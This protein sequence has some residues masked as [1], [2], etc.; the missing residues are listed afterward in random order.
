MKRTPLWF[1]FVAISA[2]R[3]GDAI[4]IALEGPRMETVER[5]LGLAG[6][7]GILALVA[8]LITPSEKAR[9]TP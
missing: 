5:A 2:V 7:A 9:R 3:V 4:F 8:W 1:I 6:L